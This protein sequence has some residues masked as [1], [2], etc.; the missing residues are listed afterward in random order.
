MNGAPERVAGFHVWATRPSPDSVALIQM[1][2]TLF[3]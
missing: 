3:T 1:W 2:A